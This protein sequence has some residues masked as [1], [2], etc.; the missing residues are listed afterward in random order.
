MRKI[1]KG[2]TILEMMLVLIVIS[3]VLLIT[4]PNITQK[5]KVI[6]KVGCES[7]VEVVNAQILMY[8]LQ[9]G[10]EPDDLQALIDDGYLKESQLKCPNGQ[11]ITLDKN[12]QAVAE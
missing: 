1:Q 5:K 2:F 11:T 4:I 12:G 3:V 9:T 6:Q 10:F 7:L 8:N